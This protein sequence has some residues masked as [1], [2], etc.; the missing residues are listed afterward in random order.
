MLDGFRGAYHSGY[1]R[2]IRARSS[3]RSSSIGKRVAASFWLPKL[4]SA[5]AAH[6]RVMSSASVRHSIKK[7]VATGFAAC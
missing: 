2:Q 6:V 1:A 4:L 5:S 3:L 7:F